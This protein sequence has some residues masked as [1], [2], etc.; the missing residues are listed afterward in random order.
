MVAAETVPG[1]KQVRD[2]LVLVR[3][4]SPL[5][6]LPSADEPAHARTS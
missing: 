3:P 5:A 2:H 4:L 1:V 6:V